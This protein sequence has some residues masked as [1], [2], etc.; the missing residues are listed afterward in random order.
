M[1]NNAGPG[2]I[3]PKEGQNASVLN[4][5]TGYSNTMKACESKTRS[6]HKG[7]E[8]NN[9]WINVPGSGTGGNVKGYG[10]HG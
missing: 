5:A 8:M 10:D 7:T 6:R 9:K 3:Q 4:R 2:P 1:K